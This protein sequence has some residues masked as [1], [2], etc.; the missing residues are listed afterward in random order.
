MSAPAKLCAARVARRMRKFMGLVAFVSAVTFVLIDTVLAVGQDCQVLP[1]LPASPKVTS[2]IRGEFLNS[3]TRLVQD[4]YLRADD[5][6]QTRAFIIRPYKPQPNPG[7]VMFVHLLGPPPDNDRE[8]FFEDALELADMNIVSLLVEAPWADP[9]WFPNRKLE[10]DLP[11]VLKSAAVLQGQFRF[12]LAESKAAPEKVAFVGHDFGAMYGTLLLKSEPTI[13]HA[14]L[15]AAVPDFADWFLL[16]RKLSIQEQEAYRKTM[17]AIAA[18]RYLRCAKTANIL[19]QFAESD[20]FVSR[21]Q[22]DEFV[23]SAPAQKQVLW[24]AGGH[25]LQAPSRKDRIDWLKQNIGFMASGATTIA[26][27]SSQ[28]AK[29]EVL[30]LLNRQAEAGVRRDVTVMDE[31]L[32]QEYFHTN[33]DGSMMSRTAVLESYR[34][35]TQFTFSE[36]RLEDVKIVF[37]GDDMA[38]ANAQVVL[39]GKKGPDPFTSRYRVTYVVRRSGKSWRVLN[40]HSSLISIAPGSKS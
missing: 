35:A 39:T 31:I 26:G 4:V 23:G 17:T 16:G 13:R 38:I 33:P 21:K 15:V 12:L 28:G 30:S 9:E 5:G 20:R 7:A 32:D 34:A 29:A 14:A 37:A 10:E 3:G 18:S 24:Y 22:A 27:Q 40:S 36:E 8:E 6:S 1:A 25:E 2:K 19:F 11:N